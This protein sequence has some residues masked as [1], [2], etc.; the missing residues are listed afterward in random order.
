[1]KVYRSREGKIFGVCQGLADSTGYSAK[2]WRI[3]AVVAAFFTAG[4]AIAAYIIAAF[5]LP[6]RRP[7]GYDSKGFKENFEDLRDDAEAF[8]KREYSEFKEAGADAS[9]TRKER[10]D[11]KAA[12]A[13][14]SKIDP[15]K[16]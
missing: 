10:K 15:E 4:W 12:S 6:V 16:A 8:V 13:G 11:A 14:D 5:V 3:A 7:E 1:M 9:K 2:Y